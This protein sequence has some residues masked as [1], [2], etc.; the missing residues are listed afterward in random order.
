LCQLFHALDPGVGN[1]VRKI[2][3]KASFSVYELARE[4]FQ[5]SPLRSKD[6]LYRL[7]VVV[8]HIFREQVRNNHVNIEKLTLELTFR[9]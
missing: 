7:D 4:C 6:A 5:H 8:M 2:V 9:R 1:R 3:S